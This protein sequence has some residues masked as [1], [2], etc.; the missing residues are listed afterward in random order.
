LVELGIH[1]T[2]EKIVQGNAVSFVKNLF[3]ELFRRL[4]DSEH[5]FFAICVFEGQVKKYVSIDFEV[6]LSKYS[7]FHWKYFESSGLRK[8]TVLIYK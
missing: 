5:I 3:S 1:D 2:W 7:L 8:I 4:G 6:E